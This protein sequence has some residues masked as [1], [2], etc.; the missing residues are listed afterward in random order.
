MNREHL[1]TAHTHTQYLYK[2]PV[3]IYTTSNI[4]RR[5]I[6]FC[7]GNVFQGCARAV[8]YR[9]RVGEY[10]KEG[11]CW[12]RTARCIRKKKHVGPR[13]VWTRVWLSLP[14]RD[15]TQHTI[16]FALVVVW[17]ADIIYNIFIGFIF[18]CAWRFLTYTKVMF[19]RAQ[20]LIVICCV[21]GTRNYILIMWATLN[22]VSCSVYV[23]ERVN[24]TIYGCCG[25]G[26]F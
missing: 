14:P 9:V 11:A 4:F 3:T 15:H 2:L 25:D 6:F 12:L 23:P 22:R 10:N 7:A 19:I 26:W 8:A 21:C 16:E 20:Q 17:N 24:G 1:L 5:C 13:A 18:K